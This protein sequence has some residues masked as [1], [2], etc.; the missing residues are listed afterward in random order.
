MVNS[1][2]RKYGITYFDNN[3]SLVTQNSGEPLS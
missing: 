1:A 2:T 3:M